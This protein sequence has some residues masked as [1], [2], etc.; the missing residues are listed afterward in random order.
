MRLSDLE[1]SVVVINT[2]GLAVLAKVIVVTLGALVADTDDLLVA[3]VTKI[4]LMNGFLRNF[5]VSFEALLQAHLHQP[6]NLL[7]DNIVSSA[8]VILLRAG[9]RFGLHLLGLWLL[10]L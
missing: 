8:D 9:L 3:C 1:E 2:L 5:L 7:L 4:A 6:G 10:L